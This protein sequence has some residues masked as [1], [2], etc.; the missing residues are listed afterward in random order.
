MAFGR[1]Y[2]LYVAKARK[3][4]RTEAEVLA[5][6]AWLTGYDEE[7]LRRICDSNTTVREFF[8]QALRLNPARNQITGSICGVRV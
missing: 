2:S 7:D 3:K 6:I 1:L 5:L 4:G 8:A